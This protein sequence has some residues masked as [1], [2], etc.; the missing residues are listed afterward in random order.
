MHSTPYLSATP[1]TIAQVRADQAANAWRRVDAPRFSW[2]NAPAI[3]AAH[4]AD[5]ARIEAEGIA[6]F[7]AGQVRK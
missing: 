7:E 4:H 6:A 1:R 5:V 2:A 3:E